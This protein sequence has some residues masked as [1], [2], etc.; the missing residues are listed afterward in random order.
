MSTWNGRPTVTENPTKPNPEYR[1][2]PTA[3]SSTE[4]SKQIQNLNKLIFV[5]EKLLNNEYS[6]LNKI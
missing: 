2:R 1:T 3:L 5:R 6:K 4:V